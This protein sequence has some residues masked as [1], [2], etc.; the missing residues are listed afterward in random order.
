MN[1]AMAYK[2]QDKPLNMQGIPAPGSP[3]ETDHFGRLLLDVA[4]TRNKESFVQLFEH[5]A[6]R[7]KSFLMKGGTRED[8][9]DE[10]AQETMLTVWNKAGAYNPA[11]ASASTWIFTIARNKKI[12]ALRKTGRFEVAATDPELV[13]DEAK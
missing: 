1:T 11:Q 13:A 8:L 5:F 7:V 3:R 4:Q 10:L 12:D 6:P 9:A 2:T